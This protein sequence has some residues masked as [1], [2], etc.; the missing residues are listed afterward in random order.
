VAGVVAVTSPM[1]RWS[2][3][4][5]VAEA[6]CRQYQAGLPREEWV[7]AI[8]VGRSMARA[9]LILQGDWTALS[10]PK[11]EAFFENLRGNH[12]V[13]TVDTWMIRLGLKSN[14]ATPKR[15]TLIVTACERVAA[16]LD[17]WPAEVQA[18]AWL[19]AREGPK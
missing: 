12:D 7:P 15:L 4:I 19:V 1:L 3:N 2:Q 11:V 17:M 8:Y 10:G 6:Y 14:E 5:K 18:I 13:V 16:K 9:H